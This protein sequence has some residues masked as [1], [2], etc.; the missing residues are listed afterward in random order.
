M[1][2]QPFASKKRRFK[3]FANTNSDAVVG[4]TPDPSDSKKLKLE[5]EDVI[6]Q[7]ANFNFSEA[8]K[9]SVTPV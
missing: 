6:S 8:P 4:Q 7:L 3:E 1:K 9:M 5:T 2:S